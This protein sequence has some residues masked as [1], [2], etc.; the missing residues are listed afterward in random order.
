M[1]SHLLTPFMQGLAEAADLL[2]RRAAGPRLPVEFRP[3]AGAET[4]PRCVAVDGSSAV[5]VDSGSAWVV[6]VRAT[7]V[8]WPGE[9]EPE[10]PAQVIATLPGDAQAKV[11][12]RYAPLGLPIPAARTADA[13]ADAFRAAAELEA[14]LAAV[15][16]MAPGSLLLVDGA[17]VGLPPGPA[18]IAARIVEACRA[19][20]VRVAGIA[21]RSGIEHGST[22]LVPALMAGASERGIGG[23][24]SVE[25]EPGVQVAKLHA[26]AQHAFRV[27]AA[28]D[29]L[30]ALAALSRDAVY[31][32]Y[33]YPLAVAHN[34]VALTGG[35]VRELKAR[36]DLELRKRGAAT[37]GLAR[38]FHAVLD[39]N[40]PG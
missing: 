20:G 40:V 22:P 12:A 38:D 3:I 5:L 13:F 18:A 8:N 23:P 29:L 2:A 34:R 35:H 30:P 16:Q 11:D 17:L 27:D 1:C 15:A 19:R 9:A 28:A 33:P 31:T 39:A 37:V 4:P 6:A 32:G 14:A 26:A 10:P 24:W 25:A 21:K 36:L 7:A